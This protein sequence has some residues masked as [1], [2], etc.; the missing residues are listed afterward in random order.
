M[1]ATTSVLDHILARH[2]PE[3]QWRITP[4]A[5]GLQK[6]V[7]VAQNEQHKLIIKFDSDTPAWQRLAEIGVTPPLLGRGRYEGRPYIIQQFVEGRSPDRDWLAQNLAVLAQFVH[8]YHDDKQLK[9]ILAA[10]QPESHTEQVRE[11]VHTLETALVSTGSALFAPDHFRRAFRSFREQARR[12]APVP[13]VPVHA[14]PSP[15]NMLVTKQ[16]LTMVDWDD[17]LL[18]DP[19][20]DVGLMVWWYLL[21][22]SWPA[23]FDLYGTPAEPGRIFWWVAKRS[24]EVAL[25]FD[26]QHADAPAHAFLDDFYAAVH[27]QDNPRI[28][29]A[30]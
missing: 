20:R 5:S 2:F 28:A 14:D 22:T 3:Q 26:A 11:E 4:P 12:L 9:E 6:E 18:S 19:M 29:A 1:E 13:L 23:F 8:R 10:S 25:W 27:H 17:V 24:L 16:A 15:A 21:P 7:Y 30:P